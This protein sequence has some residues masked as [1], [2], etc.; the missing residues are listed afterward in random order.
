MSAN[1]TQSASPVIL[2]MRGITKRYPGV[3]ALSD[4]SLDLRRGEV[5]AVMGENGAGKSTLMKILSGA[6]M[7]DMGTI[8]V[9]GKPV[10]LQSIAHAT[11][12]G[13]ALVHQEL[14]L[15]NNLDIAANIFLGAES[16]RLGMLDK[17]AMHRESRKWLDR[18]GLHIST[19]TP[20]GL[21]TAGQM[22]MVEIAKAL[23]H[24]A[25]ILILDEPTSSLSHS[26]SEQLFRIMAELKLQGVSIIY[27]SHRMEEVQ[28]LADSV[29]VLRD[30][31]N[32]GHMDRTEATKEKIVSMMVGRALNNWYPPKRN[33]TG[34]TVALKVENLHVVGTKSP[35]SF[36][37]RAG[38][39][40]GFAGLVGAGRTELVET[41]FGVTPP[42]GG[43]IELGGRHFTPT[44]PRD[45][46]KRGIYLAPEDRKRNGL[47]LGM[48]VA[49]NISLPDINNYLP[50][51]ML[52]PSVE[53]R[54]AQQQVDQL[55]IKTPSTRQL[56]G[57]L[58]GGTQ[59]K[60]VLGKW[61]AMKPKVLMLDEPTRGVDVGAKAEIY[62]QI[63]ELADAGIAII[64]VSSEMEEILGMADRVVIMRDR[65][66][67]GI[68]PR[69]EV[70][71]EVI[72]AKMI[73]E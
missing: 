14:M 69:D 42:L 50:R 66:I 20:A 12:L 39:I 31:K 53:Q 1:A 67:A 29:T 21:L 8:E 65:K 13:I 72:A 30:G 28:R 5:L 3:I 2:S 6:V 64:F 34:Q 44:A 16:A 73:G 60:V 17:A 38:E 45:A 47:V 43:H 4:V 37:V 22:Q 57:M 35:V 52:R 40:L 7:P 58:S 63:R 71:Q 9:D 26:E 27:I 25:R 54:V 46:I 41:V 62:R 56:V 19:R 49:K 18:V 70:S 48:S 23:S 24:K 32:V 68:Y 55:R 36:D 11:L 33:F 51:W 61:L 59:Q 10:A 15:A